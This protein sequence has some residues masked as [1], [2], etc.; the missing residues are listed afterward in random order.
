MIDYHFSERNTKFYNVFFYKVSTKDNKKIVTFEYQTDSRI[1]ENNNSY[2]FYRGFAS[3]IYPINKNQKDIRKTKDEDLFSFEIEELTHL[4]FNNNLNNIFNNISKSK[5]FTKSLTIKETYEI[6]DIFLN[7]LGNGRELLH[8]YDLNSYIP[9]G[10]YWDSTYY[11]FSSIHENR[12][13]NL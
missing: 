1:D 2:C 5:M 3:G 8:L 7:N 11:Y 10:D 6:N 13:E 4:S 12:K 9:D